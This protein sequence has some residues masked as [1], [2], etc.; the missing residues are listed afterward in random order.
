MLFQLPHADYPE[1]PPPGN[2][3]AYDLIPPVLQAPH[4]RWTFGAM[5]AREEGNWYEMVSL[6]EPQKLIATLS[7]TGFR[8]ITINRNGYRDQ[9]SSL[10]QSLSKLG[11]RQDATSPDKTTVLYSLTDSATPE[12]MA[13]AVAPGKGWYSIETTDSDPAIWSRGDA[14]VLVSNVESTRT[15]CSVSFTLR[16]LTRR[17]VHLVEGSKTLASAALAPGEFAHLAAD[18][19][20]SIGEPKRLILHSEEPAQIPG[21]GDSRPLAFRWK[22]DSSPICY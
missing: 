7:A 19:Q 9:A 16:S 17:T 18:I 11:L 15:A 20:L 4:L 12:H 10:E 22:I 1:S 6:L 2:L 14:D 3:E 13:L 21:N 5:K 8:G